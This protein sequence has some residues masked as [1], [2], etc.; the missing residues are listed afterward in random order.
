MRERIRR[1]KLRKRTEVTLDDIARE[2]NPIVRGW[3]A[4]YGQYSR[5]ALYPMARYINETLYVWFKRKYK[6][7]RKRLGQ[8]RLFVAKIARENRKLF[9]HWQ[10]GNGTELA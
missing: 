6:R 4:Y 10:L 3:I 7:F 9:V 8:A 5:S 2:I 1:L